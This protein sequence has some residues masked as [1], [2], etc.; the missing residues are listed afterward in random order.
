MGSATHNIKTFLYADVIDLIHK[1]KFILLLNKFSSVHVL[2]FPLPFF[3]SVL[4]GI[5]NE[6]F[7]SQIVC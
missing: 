6:S 5:F 4:Y 3:F 7:L 1:A 2:N